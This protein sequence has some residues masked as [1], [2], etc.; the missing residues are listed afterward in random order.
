VD[1]ILICQDKFKDLSLR[2]WF[3]GLAL[4]ALLSNTYITKLVD[5]ASE[6]DEIVDFTEHITELAYT[7][8]D[9]MLKQ[10]EK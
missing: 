7:T 8:A 2:D 10:K 6:D 9:N 1:D 4:Q 5:E 3:A